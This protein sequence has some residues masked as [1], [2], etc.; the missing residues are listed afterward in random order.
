[1]IRR[2]PRSTL[3]P[4]T[5]LFRSCISERLDG[6]FRPVAQS[7]APARNTCTDNEPVPLLDSARED[8]VR[9]AF[10]ISDVD[11]VVAPKA[12]RGAVESAQPAKR[13][14]LGIFPRLETAASLR[15][16]A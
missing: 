9:V 3:F 6:A 4:Y 13:L 2:P 14:S 15:L 8:V 7:S 16:P 1:M 5:T 11:D 12:L 10:A